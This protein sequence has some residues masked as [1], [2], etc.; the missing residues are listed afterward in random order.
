MTQQMFG[1]GYRLKTVSDVTQ[2]K[3]LPRSHGAVGGPTHYYVTVPWNEAEYSPN[4]PL[5]GVSVN[6]G[7][8]FLYG[9]TVNAEITAHVRLAV[10]Q[11]KASVHLRLYK[12]AVINGVETRLWG[13]E[14]PESFIGEGETHVAS[15]GTVTYSSSHILGHWR[16]P[17]LAEGERLRLEVDS[18]KAVN[19]DPDYETGRIIGARIEGTYWRDLLTAP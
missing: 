16:V 19:P 1:F 15:D 13:S 9:P 8:T 12:V 14:S 18:W 3:A 17:P 4:D 6:N 10:M 2:G 7:W 5:N 11:E